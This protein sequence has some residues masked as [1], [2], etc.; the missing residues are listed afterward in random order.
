MRRF[1]R[2]WAMTIAVLWPICVSAEVQD[3]DRVAHKIHDVLKASGRMTGSSFVIKCQDGTACLEGHVRS[4]EQKALA[5]RLTG[6]VPEVTDVVDHLHVEPAKKPANP[7]VR[8]LS[9]P[10][11]KPSTDDQEALSPVEKDEPPAADKKSSFVGWF[12][13]PEKAAA[14]SPVQE[15]EEL[16]PVEQDEPLS[17][18]EKPSFASWFKHPAVHAAKS[19]QSKARKGLPADVTPDEM[20]TLAADHDS[21]YPEQLADSQPAE[22][23]NLLVRQAANLRA[24]FSRH[25][26][27]SKYSVTQVSQAVPQHSMPQQSNQAAPRAATP[28]PG[29]CVACEGRAMTSSPKTRATQVANTKRYYNTSP[30]PGASRSQSTTAGRVKMV[31]MIEM[32]DGSLVPVQQSRRAP[33]GQPTSTQRVSTGSRTR[34]V[35]SSRSRQSMARKQEFIDG[36]VDVEPAAPMPTGPVPTGPVNRGPLPSYVPGAAVGV[37]PAYYD[38]PH[39]PNYAWPSYAAHPNYAGLTYPRQYSPTAW[40]YIGPFYPYPQVPLG[41]RKV[42]LEWDDGWWFL[43]FDDTNRSYAY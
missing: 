1:I 5:L 20:D 7:V 4:E 37:A 16:P 32:A 40:P 21:V 34:A 9:A 3:N 14:K 23:R 18:D 27:S 29:N 15:Q 36:P 12:K 17:E 38:Q 2:A 35:A 28:A 8:L 11:T 6:E 22:P 41:W 43:D 10:F 33:L 13:H 30:A 25:E 42:T 31:P 39:M 26:S 24:I 19:P